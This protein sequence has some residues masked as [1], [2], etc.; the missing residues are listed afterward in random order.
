MT[1]L[2]LV[3]FIGI[4]VKALI[5]MI[6]DSDNKTNYNDRYKDSLNIQDRNFN[7]N[8]IQ[9]ER[10]HQG[11]IISQMEQSNREQELL[12][13]QNEQINQYFEQ[14]LLRQQNE[15]LTESIKIVTP[16]EHGGYDMTQGNSFNHLNM[17]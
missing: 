3:L 6:K 15:Q 2:V 14:E 7:A 11:F 1:Q 17:F 5:F 13:Q 9:Q 4:I 12:R 10:E 8:S 16:F